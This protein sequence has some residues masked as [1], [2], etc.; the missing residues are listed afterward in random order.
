MTVREASVGQVAKWLAAEEPMTLI[1]VRSKKLY[2]EGHL[3]SAICNT[4]SSFDASRIANVP[5][6]SRIVVYCVIGKASSAVAEYLE[7]LRYSRVYSMS[8][9]IKAWRLMACAPLDA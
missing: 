9:G 1:D 2:D 7:K 5:R 4:A 6:D 3:P 8:G